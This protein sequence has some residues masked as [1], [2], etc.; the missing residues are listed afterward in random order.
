MQRVIL[1]L[2]YEPS[3]PATSWMTS[4]EC[5]F[6]FSRQG[7]GKWRCKSR[8]KWWE[9]ESLNVLKWIY[10]SLRDWRRMNWLKYDYNYCIYHQRTISHSSRTVRTGLWNISSLDKHS[11]R[12]SIKL[13][14]CQVCKATLACENIRFSTLFAAGDVS[15]RGTSATQWQKFHTDDVKSVRNPVR[16]TDWSME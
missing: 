1:P 2:P 13:I 12:L 7:K 4:G 14:I 11:P 8:A 15:C 3:I 6:F 10:F 9:N 16:S 5:S